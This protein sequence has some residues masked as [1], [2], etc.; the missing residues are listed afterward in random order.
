ML[1]HMHVC[2]VCMQDGFDGLKGEVGPTGLLGPR[3]HPGTFLRRV[4]RPT[5][6]IQLI[7][8]RA[9]VKPLLKY[10]IVLSAAH[11]TFTVVSY[12]MVL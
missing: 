10:R 9:M 6:G 1:V 12:F 3:G 4:M 7:R 11:G 8:E 5:T 2:G